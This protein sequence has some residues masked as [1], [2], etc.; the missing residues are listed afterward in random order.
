M[1][2]AWVPLA[3]VASSL[4]PGLIIFCLP[5]DRRTLRTALNF[6]GAAAKLILVG[7]M[8]WNVGRFHDYEARLALLPG[9]DVVL[10]ADELSLLFLTLSAVLWALIRFGAH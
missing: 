8:L 10:R 3:V 1:T 7:I 9:L 2:E 4:L 5:E 6:G